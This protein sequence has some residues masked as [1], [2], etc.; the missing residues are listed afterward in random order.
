M[1]S[2]GSL[3]PQQQLMNME[4]LL[5]PLPSSRNT[6]TTPE[7]SGSVPPARGP[8]TTPT[9][10]VFLLGPATT[11]DPLM[12][13]TLARAHLPAHAACTHTTS[14]YPSRDTQG[15]PGAC[16]APRT[17]QLRKEDS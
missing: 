10:H 12:W 15:R 16:P 6:L 9:V 8:D 1:G 2:G 3:K 13:L 7:D 5:R 17:E 11:Q 4:E 14:V